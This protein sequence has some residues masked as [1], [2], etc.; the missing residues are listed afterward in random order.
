MKKAKI[1]AFALLTIG[2]LSV[3]LIYQYQ[4]YKKEASELKVA[5][6]KLR[7]LEES[8]KPKTEQERY[9]Q[10][11]RNE[12]AKAGMPAR[13]YKIL[14]AVIFCES[15]WRQ[16]RANGSVVIS[17]GN[18]G[19]GQINKFAHEKTYTSMGLDPTDP[20]D[21]LKFTIFLYQR[22]GLKP[23]E[24]WSGSCWEPKVEKI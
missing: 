6:Q 13:T 9:K 12:I 8:T 22:D 4:L 7:E 1:I 21:N 5:Q 11:L 20:Y 19:L 24:H 23:W 17:S 18:I 14:S 10:F 15:S 3:S 2:V 16:Y